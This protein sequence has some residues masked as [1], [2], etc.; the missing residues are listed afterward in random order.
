MNAMIVKFATC[1]FAALFLCYCPN[2][3]TS[4]AAKYAGDPFQLGVGARAVGMGGAHSAAVNDVTAGFW[5]PAGLSSIPNRQVIFMHSETFGLLLN[6]DYIAFASPLRSQS[7][8]AVGA[9]SLTRLGGGGIKLTE[10]DYKF[11]RPRVVKESGHADYQVI[12]SYAA[13]SSSRF[14]FGGSAKILYRNIADNSAYGI[15]A[16]LGVQCELGANMTAALMVRDASTTLLSYDTGT[17]ESIY[18][19]MVP[20]FS[21][22]QTMGDF[23]IVATA[24]AEVRFENYR[25][26]A[27]YWSGSISADT[28]L[29]CEIGFRERAFGR[30][31]SDIGRLT[32]GCGISVSSLEFDL[33]YM[34]QTDIDDSFRI[35]LLYNMK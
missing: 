27:Q 3:G 6:H 31:G 33:A 11:N 1:V 20:G 13:G 18:P 35:S 17:K 15:G 30:I 34:R 32:L 9:I 29:G 4:V 14:R 22:R 25:E 28:H 21:T 23:S 24:D 10:W 16:D 26:A 5:N 12:F 19:T 8:S 2:A 7:G